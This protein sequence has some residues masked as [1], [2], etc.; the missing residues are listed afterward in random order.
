MRTTTT[1]VHEQFLNRWSSRSFDGT[2]VSDEER[3]TLFEA[4]R[5]APSSYNEQPW[6]FIYPSPERYEH[7]FALLSEGNRAWVQHAGLLCFL[8][9]KRTL[10]K[11]GE[12][13]RFSFFDA[14]SAW[15]SFALQA[16][17][18]GLSAHAM[19][20]FDL[21]RSYEV[22]GIDRATHETVAAIAVGTPT[23][24]AQASEERTDRRALSE[25]ATRVVQ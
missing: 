8:T 11:T 17:H 13:N 3:D 23:K 14:G 24:E 7:F 20:G 15:M 12:Q 19:G 25:I 16:A 5:F 1:A 4:A 21:E 9:A 10:E 6:Q 22:L 2:P 18:L